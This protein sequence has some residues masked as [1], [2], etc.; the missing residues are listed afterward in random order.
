MIP[1]EYYTISF[2]SVLSFCVLF[3]LMPLFKYY[4]L[5]RAI[6]SNLNFKVFIILLLPI[7]FIGFRDAF[8]DKLYLGDT[9][10]YT[11]LYQNL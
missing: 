6:G 2:Y 4:N 1:I 10:S 8:G 5:Q 3:M 9:L 11:L 7:L